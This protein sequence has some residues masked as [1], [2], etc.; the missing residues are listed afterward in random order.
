MKRLI[1]F[2]CLALLA[3]YAAWP[4]YSLYE[5]ATGIKAK[6]ETTIARKVAW[7]PLRQ[8][9]KAP[10][11]ERVNKEIANQSKGQGIEGVIAAE[12]ASKMTPQLVEKILDAYV[13]PKGVIALAN[14]GGKIETSNLGIGNALQSL[15]GKSN[16][17]N[18]LLGSLLGKAKDIVG[19]TPGG[20][21]LLTSTLGK[22]GK[23]LL[24][25]IDKESSKD[26]AAGKSPSYGLHNIKSFNF[27]NPWSFEVGL[28]KSPTATKPDVIAGMSFIDRDWKLS[29][30]IPTL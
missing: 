9:L 12:L 3:F 29:K 26:S 1:F 2:L 20:K 10:V 6:E 17:D 27:I 14:Q 19:A 8:S 16:G 21:D 7:G 15:S 11:T 28:A 24:T 22:V 13:T 30:L 5:L 18:G 4:A 25:D 23:D